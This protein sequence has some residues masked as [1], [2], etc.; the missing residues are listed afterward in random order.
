MIDLTRQWKKFQPQFF[1]WAIAIGV[2]LVVLSGYLELAHQDWETWNK[3]LSAVGVAILVSG[4]FASLL[5][6]FQFAGVFQEELEKFFLRPELTSRLREVMIYGREDNTILKKAMEH[7]ARKL[8]NDL[9]IEG[10]ATAA[11]K[12]LATQ[13]DYSVRHYRRKLVVCDYDT[14]TQ[15]VTVRD[16]LFLKIIAHEPTA[17]RGKYKGPGFQTDNLDIRKLE[18]SIDHG[19][20]RSIEKD[21]LREGNTINFKFDISPRHSYELT[22][23]WESHYP[24]HLDPIIQTQFTRLCDEQELTIVNKVP[25]KIDFAVQYT[26]HEHQPVQNNLSH[27][28]DEIEHLY[29][30]EH[31]TF[32]LQGYIVTLNPK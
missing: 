14:A 27:T 13:T 15:V 30:V 18:L 5:K 16:Y 29:R 17:F 3:K 32:P 1:W 25:A 22:R 7:L 12:V 6:S 10:I 21:I 11:N 20:P 24:L 8:L 2:S 4:V 23:V 26:N 9:P 19:P 28:P 31:L